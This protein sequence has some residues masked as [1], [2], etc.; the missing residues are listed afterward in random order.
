MGITTPQVLSWNLHVTLKSCISWWISH[1]LANLIHTPSG[2]L[3][4]IQH[5]LCQ[6]LG[7]DFS[8]NR[9]LPQRMWLTVDH[10]PCVVPTKH[11]ILDDFEYMYLQDKLMYAWLGL[12]VHVNTDNGWTL[13]IRTS[14]SNGQH[15]WACI[16]TMTKKASNLHTP[17]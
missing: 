15:P 17:Q 16:Q 11:V 1:L 12:Y 2:F 14:K 6:Q 10:P 5:K 9:S 7:W 4:R 3:T 13:F 8:E